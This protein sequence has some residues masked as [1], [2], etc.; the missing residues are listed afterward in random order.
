MDAEGITVTYSLTGSDASKF[1]LKGTPPVLSFRAKPD[2]EAKADANRDN[3]YEVTV[4]ATA[5][6]KSEDRMVRVIVTNVDEGPEIMAGGLSVSG[7]A[8][9]NYAEDGTGPVATY[10]ARGANAA[11]ARWTLEGDDRGAFMLSPTTGEST[12]LTFRSPPDYEDKNSYMVTVKAEDG[13]NDPATREVPVNITNVDE[14]GEVT[15]SGEPRVGETIMASLMDPDNPDGGVTDVTWQWASADMMDGTY[16]DITNATSTS[17]TLVE[18][19]EGMHLRATATYTDLHDS[20]QTAD[21]HPTASVLSD[22]QAPTFATATTSRE[23]AENSATSTN[24]GAPVTA[25]DPD[26]DD[27]S[28]ALSGADMAS[29]GIGTA[30]GQLTTMAALDFETETSYSVTVTATDSAGKY[31]MITVTITVTDEEEG[32]L[33]RYDADSDDSIQLSEA[34]TAVGDYFKQPK[35]S[36]LSLEDAREV[37]GLYF[38]Y[39]NSQ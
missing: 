5:G 34:R 7:P 25:D 30:T 26:G 32:L 18:T 38:K 35:G 36:V 8:S 23:V 10:T 27:L 2:Y 22:N 17:Y 12:M 33:D 6:G 16:T 21:S 13:E 37:V 29:F 9:V 3:V 14:D 11:S 31:A 39:K 20:D 4:R 1:Q 15:L 24:V 28:Y 19:D